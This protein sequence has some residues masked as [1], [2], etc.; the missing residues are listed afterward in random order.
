M[1][2]KIMMD[3]ARLECDGRTVAD[4]HSL[5]GPPVD[6]TKTNFDFYYL[7]R[8]YQGYQALVY[9]EFQIV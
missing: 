8:S 2:Y 6:L 9:F 4:L 3:G 1:G 5:H 7:L